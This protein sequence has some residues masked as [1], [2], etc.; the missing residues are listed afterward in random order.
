MKIM[1][2]EH[3]ILLALRAGGT[4][5]TI[6]QIRL[7]LQA[8]GVLASDQKLYNRLDRLQTTGM[9]FPTCKLNHDYRT[10]WGITSV[11]VSYLVTHA[12]GPTM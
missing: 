8:H 1:P 7:L 11:G 12:D 3:C 9:V 2:L 6:P 5:Q 4:G 10:I